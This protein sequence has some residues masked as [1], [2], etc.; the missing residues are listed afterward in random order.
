MTTGAPRARLLP[1]V[2]AAE[3]PDACD[4]GKFAAQ[5]PAAPENAPNAALK[6]SGAAAAFKKRYP[7]WPA[8]LKI[9]ANFPGSATSWPTSPGQKQCSAPV[10]HA[11]GSNDKLR[12]LRAPASGN[13][14]SA[15]RRLQAYLD[16]A[17]GLKTVWST[18][19][20]KRLAPD[21]PV[22]DALRRAITSA[23]TA[24][25]EVDSWDVSVEPAE[26]EVDVNVDF[27]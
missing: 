11:T 1:F 5:V 16:T 21:M 9:P 20:L 18:A 10:R 12:L 8:T 22:S 17:A 13:A 24:G 26:V 14:L 7:E 2:P 4:F 19:E 23:K 6:L 27:E 15:A 25:S 3:R